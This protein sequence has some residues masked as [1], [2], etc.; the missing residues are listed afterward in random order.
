[1]HPV[2]PPPSTPTPPPP[3]RRRCLGE[4]ESIGNLRAYNLQDVYLVL[5]IDILQGWRL[6]V[7]LVQYK[8]SLHLLWD[9]YTFRGSTLPCTSL[10]HLLRVYSTFYS[11][12]GTSNDGCFMPSL[13]RDLTHYKV[14]FWS[15]KVG[16]AQKQ[17][18]LEMLQLT[19]T[20]SRLDLFYYMLAS[21]G[22]IGGIEAFT[23]PFMGILHFLWVY[24][25]FHVSTLPLN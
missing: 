10:L 16:P 6:M 8:H 4:R 22:T 21:D 11:E 3:S 14:A 1:M 12:S 19:H 20:W 17:W 15:Y 24:P 18:S 23:S 7:Q 5:R 2:P 25:T 13:G 9:Y